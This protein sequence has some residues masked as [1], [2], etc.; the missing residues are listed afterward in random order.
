MES[1]VGGD[2]KRMFTGSAVILRDKKEI[3]N[4]LN[5][6]PV[7]DG[8]TGVNMH[9]T[10]SFAVKQL[11]EDRRG[12]RVGD[13]ARCIAHNLLIGARGNSGVILS[14]LFRGFAKKLADNDAV[15]PRG[16]TRALQEGVDT[17]YQAVMKPVEGTMLTVARLAVQEATREAQRGAGFPALLE[18]LWRKGEEALQ[19]TPELL[20]VLKEA[21]V[22]DAGGM[23]LCA[24]YEGFMKA[25][26]GHHYSIGDL[27]ERP[28][29]PRGEPAGGVPGQVSPAGEAAL[30]YRYCTELLVKGSRL[31]AGTLQDSLAAQGDSLLVVGGG[32]ILKV[33]VH[34]NNPGTVLEKCLLL[35]E[36]SQVKIDNMQEQHQEFIPGD[37]TR[38]GRDLPAPAGIFPGREGS[39]PVTRP[40]KPGGSVQIIAVSPGEGISNI[41]YSLG[42]SRVI[43]GGQTMNPST[44][45]LLKAVEEIKAEKVIILPNNKNI[46]L[47]ARQARSLS[48]K[49]IQVVPS[50]TITQGLA[51]LLYFNPALEDLEKNALLMAGGLGEVKSG[52]VTFAVKDST[53]NGIN[54]RNGSVIGLWEDQL[55]VTGESPAE[56]VS[57]LVAKM[58]GEKDEVITLYYGQEIAEE[59]AR[60]LSSR[61]QDLYPHC[62]VE[63]YFG[64]QPLYYYYISIE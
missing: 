42:V 63:Y 11:G 55:E 12:E 19:G 51:S 28:G 45:E 18:V 62:Q 61:L 48:K 16:F 40:E 2:L 9:L 50:K 64:G 37:G 8:D 10:L 22:V 41:F 36:L 59:N 1:L 38:E 5:V 57:A 30:D 54:I 33:H 27:E 23:G 43:Q 25:L 24:I 29:D 21:G 13:V 3:I 7:P 44:E 4:S 14:Q 39:T 15:D 58:L 46:I 53:Y 17:A 60:E 34:T 32:G 56:V 20:P 31:D 47:A 35:G 49:E 52:Q 26:Q 6:F